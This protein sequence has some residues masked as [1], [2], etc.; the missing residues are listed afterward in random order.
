MFRNA[1]I[2][3]KVWDFVYGEGIVTGINE[4]EQYP[5]TVTFKDGVHEVLFSYDGKFNLNCNQSL[6][7]DRFEFTP[8]IKPFD[9]VDYLNKNLIKK[10]FKQGDDNFYLYYDHTYNVWDISKNIRFE[11]MKVYFDCIHI[12]DKLIFNQVAK[13]LTDKKITPKQLKQAYKSLN[14]I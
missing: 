11:E 3:D 10:E 9:L 7:W 4:C 1:K 12:E 6:F 13:T 5:L 8:P 14:W 2:G